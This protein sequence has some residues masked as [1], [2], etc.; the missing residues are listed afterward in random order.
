MPSYDEEEYFAV[1]AS[2]D[3]AHVSLN[4]ESHARPATAES[5]FLSSSTTHRSPL[6]RIDELPFILDLGATCH[7][8]LE[9]SDV[10]VRV[11]R[12]YFRTSRTCIM[13]ACT[14]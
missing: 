8:S 12:P 10:T 1:V 3:D 11:P 14:P 2:T 4:W 6:V 9:A 5:G 13:V 7:I